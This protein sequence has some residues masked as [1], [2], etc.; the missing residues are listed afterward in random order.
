[1]QHDSCNSVI[2]SFFDHRLIAD[3]ELVQWRVASLNLNSR[4]FADLV[5]IPRHR[6]KNYLPSYKVC[7]R[8]L[9]FKEQPH[10]PKCHAL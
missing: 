2:C 7:G 10:Y 5:I 3:S 9:D 6:M 1:M 4:H 8:E